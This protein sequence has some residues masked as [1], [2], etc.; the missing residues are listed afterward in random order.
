MM[1]KA[2]NLGYDNMLIGKQ[3][4]ILWRSLLPSPSRISV[5]IAN[6]HGVI[7]HKTLILMAYSHLY[8]A[9]YEKDFK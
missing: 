3:L 8:H 2:S 1:K 7:S 9:V 4:L 6:Q 5:T